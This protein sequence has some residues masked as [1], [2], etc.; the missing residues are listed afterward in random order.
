MRVETCTKRSAP[1]LSF[2][3]LF[4]YIILYFHRKNSVYKNPLQDY[5]YQA[6]NKV[7]SK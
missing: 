3:A 1:R 5:K 2:F 4:Y 7:A 6:E